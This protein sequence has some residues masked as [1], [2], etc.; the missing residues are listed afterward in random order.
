MTIPTP[1]Q[2]L[3]LGLDASTQAVKASLLSSTLDIVSE[4]AVNFDSDLPHYKTNGGVLHGP[5]GSGE[6]FSPVML[7]VEAMDLLFERIQKAGWDVSR[8][9]GISAA[10]QVSLTAR[11]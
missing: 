10:G 6:V 1:L 7:I 4:I 2:D 8:I 11:L 3:F 5:K 9:R